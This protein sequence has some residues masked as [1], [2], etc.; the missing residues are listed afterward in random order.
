M[1]IL[2]AKISIQGVRPL[3]WHHL[4]PEA[5]SVKPRERTGKA[6]NDPSEWRRTVLTTPKRQLY[7][8]PTYI[9]GCL[10]EAAKYSRRKLGSFQS[11]I[12]ATVQVRD[13]II[14][15]DQYLPKTDV[16]PQDKNRPVPVYLD[17]R[18]V[19]NPGTRAMNIRYRVAAAS[20]WKASFTIVW[21]NTVIGREQMES[22]LTDAG[23]LVGIGS[24]RS[25]GLGRFEITRL[26]VSGGDDA[27]APAAE[28]SLGKNSGKRVAAR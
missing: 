23:N 15:I 27:E 3:L 22:I 6:G 1:S 20:G 25:L 4:S 19:R 12:S 7:I 18:A 2:S 11:L 24:G 13:E 8:E 21:D 5:L 17:V 28:R 9:F 26:E 14:L 10:R 16:K